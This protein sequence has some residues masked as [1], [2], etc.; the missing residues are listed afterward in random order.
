[1]AQLQ[2]LITERDQIF[3]ELQGGGLNPEQFNEKIERYGE[4]G[5]VITA[6]TEKVR[7]TRRATYGE[8]L[9]NAFKQIVDGSG[10][11]TDFEMKPGDT[12]SFSYTHV[13]GEEKPKCR[14]TTKPSP[15]LVTEPTTE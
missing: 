5:L 3:G 13:M 14:I 11:Y 8:S 9:G 7:K 1:M 12:L 4:L 6:E 10:V 15:E 2:E